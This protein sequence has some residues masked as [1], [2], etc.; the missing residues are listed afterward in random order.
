MAIPLILP[1]ELETL[2][3]V[4]TDFRDSS[5]PSDTVIAAKYRITEVLGRLLAESRP[6]TY[7]CDTDHGREKYVDDGYRKAL[8]REPRLTFS[9]F[10]KKFRPV[11]DDSDSDPRLET[12]SFVATDR[13]G[14][15]GAFVLYNI[16]IDIDD[17]GEMQITA[18]PMPAMRATTGRDIGG[19][20]AGVMRWILEHDLGMADGRTLYLTQWR[21]PQRSEHRW[22]NDDAEENK[23]GDEELKYLGDRVVTDL[24]DHDVSRDAGVPISIRRKAPVTVNVSR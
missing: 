16:H 18:M 3:M 17:P 7:V 2:G 15:L 10:L 14:V 4:L 23:I 9:M 20:W 11:R 22:L 5:L 12:L 8:K 13:S 19:V 24:S 21:L 1:I 6:G